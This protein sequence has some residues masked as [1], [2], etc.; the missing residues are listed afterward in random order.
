MIILELKKGYI[1]FLEKFSFYEQY[2]PMLK[3]WLMNNISNYELVHIHSVFNYTSYVAMTCARL[4]KIPYVLRTL[5]HLNE[6]DLQ[7]NKL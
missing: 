6:Y 1:Y 5:G 4:N 2:V 3:F 7:K